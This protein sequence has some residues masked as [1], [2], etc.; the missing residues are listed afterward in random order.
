VDSSALD[1]DGFWLT[2][3][4]NQVQIVSTN[5]DQSEGAGDSD[6]TQ[7][8]AVITPIEEGNLSHVKLYDS[9]VT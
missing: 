1:G 3:E 4:I 6:P 9:G 5:P 7:V 8:H 2:E